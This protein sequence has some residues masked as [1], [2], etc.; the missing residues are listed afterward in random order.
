MKPA[1]RRLLI[2][3][4]PPALLARL[5][6]FARA[7][8]AAAGTPAKQPPPPQSAGKSRRRALSPQPLAM[9]IDS[10][11]A[12]GGDAAAEQAAADARFAAVWPWYEQQAASVLAESNVGVCSSLADFLAGQHAEWLLRWRRRSDSPTADDDGFFDCLAGRL[13]FAALHSGVNTPDRDAML[14]GLTASLEASGNFRLAQVDSS[15][16]V[17]STQLFSKALA[18]WLPEIGSTPV[19]AGKVSVNI[20]HTFLLAAEVYQSVFG[21]AA[22]K[23]QKQQKQQ[24][25]QLV[26]LIRDFDETTSGKALNK[27]ILVSSHYAAQ[28]PVACVCSL[29]KT[30][31]SLQ[32]LLSSRALAR[33]SVRCFRSAPAGILFD[34]VL[35]R[36]LINCRQWH[37]RLS[38]PT[39]DCLVEA[40]DEREFSIAA[41]MLRL[42]LALLGHIGAEDPAGTAHLR[43]LRAVP[44][45]MQLIG[46][47]LNWDSRRDIYSLLLSNRQHLCDSEEYLSRLAALLAESTETVLARVESARQL[48]NLLNEDCD[49]LTQSLLAGWSAYLDELADELTRRR[50]E[51]AA[52][53]EPAVA[54]PGQGDHGSEHKLT[55]QA[56]RQQLEAEI[57][58]RAEQTK[59]GANLRAR[60]ADCLNRRLRADLQAPLPGLHA[61]CR[62][63]LTA[64]FAADPA[65]WLEKQLLGGDEAEVS[66]SNGM[67]DVR[68]AFRLV[69]ECRR[70]VRTVELMQSFAACRAADGDAGNA[71]NSPS[72]SQMLQVRFMRA[73][74]QLQLMGFVKISAQRPDRIVRLTAV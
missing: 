53:T 2:L 30:L 29:S 18:Q 46:K 70:L 15:D 14:S 5:P 4:G 12:G 51:T 62:P 33:L 58:R 21:A 69:K 57:S 44:L 25:P 32:S 40:F 8:G 39:F 16:L 65:G 55:R 56:Q 22:D 50:D 72:P 42:R 28:L 23:R 10:G 36:V 19:Q 20:K 26:L 1:P 63:A 41:F 54:S 17:S 6:K 68:V 31:A 60:L 74:A 43:Q 7:S 59:I 67:A 9:K 45:V 35:D 3:D 66:E 37:F 73:C 27:F 11:V 24:P 64:A 49:S 71:E 61:N 47:L 52:L 34:R 48:L 13:P 38:R